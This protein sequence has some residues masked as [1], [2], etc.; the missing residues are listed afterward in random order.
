MAPKLEKSFW[1]ARI[2]QG[3]DTL[4]SHAMN[5]YNGPDGGMMPARGGNPSLSD[6][7]IKAT[8]DWM[9]SQIK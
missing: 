5:G 2:A 8:V 9:L 7:Q 3:K 4:Y 1:A 6:D